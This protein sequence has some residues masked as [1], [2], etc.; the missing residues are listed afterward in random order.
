MKKILIAAGVVLTALALTACDPMPKT[1]KAAA[2][3]AAT[4]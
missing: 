3:S 2:T 1:P 4:T